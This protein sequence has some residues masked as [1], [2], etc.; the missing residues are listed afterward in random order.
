MRNFTCFF[1]SSIAAALVAILGVSCSPGAKKARYLERANQYF[2]SGQFDKAELEYMNALQIDPKNLQALNRVGTVCFEQG[3]MGRAFLFLQMCRELDPDNLDVRG[4]LGS[5]YLAAGKLK[6]ARDEATF[7]LDKKPQDDEATLL[8]AETSVTPTDIEET[9]ARLEKLPQSKERAAAQVAA[10]ILHRRQ[11]D[12]TAAEEDFKRAQTIDPKCSAAYYAL[13]NLYWAQNDLKQAEQAFKSAAEFAP[14]RSPRR[15]TYAQF[16]IQT[17]D[18]TEGKRMLEEAVQKTPDYVPAWSG[19]AEIAVAEKK[20]DECA[21]FLE[22]IL[23]RDPLNYEGLLLRSRLKLLKGEPA[24]A[25]AELENFLKIYPQSAQGHYQLALASLAV[26]E[27]Q[28]ALTCLSQAVAADPDYADAILLQ[29]GLNISRGEISPAIVSLKRLTQRRPRNFQAQF[30]LAN[31]HRAQGNL[32]DALKV[33]RQLEPLAPKEPRIPMMMGLVLVQQGKKLEA[34]N[35]FGKVLT[36]APDYLLAVEQLL[37]LDLKDKQYAAAS[38]RVQKQIEAHPQAPEPRLLLA[39]IF[40]AQRDTNQAEAALLKAIELQP[41]FARAHL[42]LATL[43]L[44]SNQQQKALGNLQEITAKNP[45]DTGALMLTGMIQEQ[46]KNFEAAKAAYEKLLAADPKS[47]PA[48]NNLACLYSERFGQLD[49]AYEVAGR[50]RGLRPHDPYT[51]DTLGWIM[52]RKRQYPSAISLF[53]ESTEKLPD[54]PEIQFHLGMTHYAMGNEEAARIAFQQALQLNKEFPGKDQASRRLSL[55]AI[56]ARTAVPE[57][58]AALEKELAEEP[59]DPVILA[60]L[61]AIYER[62]GA[63]E[64]AVAVCQT[65][66]KANP[67]NAGAMIRLANLYS[68]H[69]KDTPKAFE[70]AKAAYKKA[71]DDPSVAQTL[72]RLAFLTGDHKWAASLLEQTARKRPEDPEVLYDFALASYSV[73]RVQEAEAAMRGALQANTS[74]SQRDEANRF[75]DLVALSLNPS[76]ALT[77]ASR[78]EQTLK[79][80]PDYVPALVVTALIDEQKSDRNAAKQ[81]YERVLARYPDFAPAKRRLAI[82]YS[83]DSSDN[84]KAYQLAVEARQAFADDPEVAKALGI[85]TYRKGDYARSASLL[86]ESAGKLSSDAKLMYY[87]GMSQYRLQKQAESKLSLQRAL[88]LNVPG[89]LAEEARRIL[90]ELK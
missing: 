75:L 24:K 85:A 74:F 62:D 52:Y 1:R 5:I 58:R 14:P 47:A 29:A 49:K 33:Y 38:E 16:K 26:Q 57:V 23:A 31:A 90:A 20:Y 82:L 36:L 68:S 59:V 37:D 43:Y 45:K 17:G 51:A 61:A 4:K 42:M 2:D 12:L 32:E 40:L 50:A 25:T 10:G 70:L 27:T 53:Q 46:L 22:K 28:K 88:D 11:R 9:R 80:N 86:K 78:V 19:L 39:K 71:P 69:L 73:G 34:R 8:L 79:S 3:R 41:E 55:L 66:V 18:L 89:E 81:T 87:L 48:L 35:A 7:V 67:E 60:R 15:L 76:Q 6:E 64:K 30:M 63:I 65:A 83:E 84:P 77:A 21:V 56:D 13:G 44:A 54:E 72:G